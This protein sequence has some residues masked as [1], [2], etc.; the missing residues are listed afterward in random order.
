M[1]DH[2]KRHKV[3][4]AF[5]LYSSFQIA[6]LRYFQSF[7]HYYYVLYS[8]NILYGH[9]IAGNYLYGKS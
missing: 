9:S 4:C 3:D 6:Q 2:E 5:E 7:N 8:N 1:R